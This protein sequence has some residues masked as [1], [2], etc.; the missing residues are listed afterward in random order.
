VPAG[1]VPHRGSLSAVRVR[2]PGLRYPIPCCCW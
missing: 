2:A 1:R